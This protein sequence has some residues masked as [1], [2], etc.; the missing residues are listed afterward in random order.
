[1]TEASFVSAKG[2]TEASTL[3]AKE[4]FSY[5][6]KKTLLDLEGGALK[7]TNKGTTT[8]ESYYA[9]EKISYKLSD[10]NYAYE[11]YRWD[12]DRFAGY[13]SRHDASVGVGRELIKKP[14]DLWIGEIGGGYI[15]EQRV[16]APVNDFATGRAYT[17][18]TRTITETS[19]FSQDAEYLQNFKNP[20]DFRSK[21]ETSITAAISTHFS[22]KMSY[23]WKHVGSPPAGFKRND[24]IATM[25]LVATY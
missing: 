5:T 15:N 21:T 18:Y 14:K 3:G 20:D 17:K 22:L 13:T 19:N 25:G 1:V 7:S 4:D 24:T 10:R 11:K 6:I 9:G 12:K 2:N 16:N 23:V 8:G